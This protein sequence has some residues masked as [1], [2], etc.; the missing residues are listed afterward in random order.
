MPILRYD[1]KKTLKQI[2][3]DAKLKNG[4]GLPLDDLRY[5]ETSFSGNEVSNDCKFCGS[6][7]PSLTGITT[8]GKNGM[9]KR[10]TE[11]FASVTVKNGYVV[12]VS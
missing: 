11:F 3:A 9:R 12:N 1:S 8:I 10:A 4:I 2:V 6:N 7:R 5:D